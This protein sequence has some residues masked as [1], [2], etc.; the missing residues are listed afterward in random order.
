MC[1]HD[2]T[3]RTTPHRP[4][5]GYSG[6][7]FGPPVFFQPTKPIKPFVK[8][9]A[10]SVLEQ[11]AG[12]SPGRTLPPSAFGGP[13]NFLGPIFM[14]ALDTNRD[15]QLSQDE[16]SAGFTRWFQTWNTDKSGSLT[17]DQLS[18]GID[19]ALSPFGG[20]PPPPAG[21]EKR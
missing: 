2:W 9:R 19:C 1:G 16:V 11:L 14:T 15:K 8:A 21:D 5:Q 4:A 13:G 6:P 20:P 17:K 18:A 7:A 3:A 10:H 12:R